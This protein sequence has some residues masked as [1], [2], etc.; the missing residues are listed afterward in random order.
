MASLTGQQSILTPGNTLTS[1]PDIEFFV[2]EKRNPNAIVEDW[3]GN[4]AY[5]MHQPGRATS[6]AVLATAQKDPVGPRPIRFG[7][8]NWRTPP[9]T[10]TLSPR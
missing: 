10:F 3:P 1:E 6:K 4:Y 2:T 5:F 9:A 8:R 7:H